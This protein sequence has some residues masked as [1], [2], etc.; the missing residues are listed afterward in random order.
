MSTDSPETP[1]ALPDRP[2][3]RHLKDQAKDLL[4]SGAAASIADAQFTI[5]RRYGFS[6]WPQLKAHVDSLRAL[7]ELEQAADAQDIER[8]DSL[9]SRHPFLHAIVERVHGAGTWL[10]MMAYVAGQ[11]AVGR[12]E[13]GQLKRAIDVED[14]DR[15]TSMMTANPG[16]HRAP[17]GYGGNGPL[18]WAAECRVPWR[19]PSATR[20]AI[21]EWMIDN[22]SDV[23]QGGDGP[24]M[25]AALNGDRVPMMALL[26]AKGADVN[27]VWNG[28]FPI[29][30]APC[31][32]VD[33]VAL[34][35]M[36]DHGANPNGAGPGRELSGTALDYLIGSYVR[37]PQLSACIDM[38]IG[39]GGTTRYNVPV[40]LN[41]LCGRLD[42]VREDL[43]ADPTLITRRFPELD[44]GASG[45]RLLTLKGATLL[46]VAVEYGNA[47]S[48]RLLLD[49][50]AHVNAPAL[51]DEAGVGGQTAIFHAVTHSE[52]R[53]VSVA[54]LLMDRGADLS[55]RVKV[56]GHYERPGE[57]IECTPLGYV[58]GVTDEPQRSK[59][60]ELLRE[61]E[62]PI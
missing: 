36:L 16:L 4:K 5:A 61:R 34:K 40:V 53:G 56:P 42:R 2:H 10:K 60:V 45:G 58:L 19:P 3:V 17:I 49:L 59:T 18:T 35:W 23:H 13:A 54:R 57:T 15:V 9:M 37:S 22:G 6:S 8:L 51:V 44:F 55:I 21:A 12:T 14:I 43:E 7:A 29:I 47:D 33:P 25:R 11:M 31:E 50:G 26:V 62:A 48:V 27:A 1:R 52:D 28:S 41:L 39:A 32:T 38:L 24:L 46:H 20:L 30:F